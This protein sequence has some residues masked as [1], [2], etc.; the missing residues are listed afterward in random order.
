MA[1]HPK[2][3]VFDQFAI[4]SSSGGGSNVE[5]GPWSQNPPSGGAD[6]P[7]PGGGGGIDG[8]GANIHLVGMQLQL[9]KLEGEVNAY[10][11]LFAAIIAILIGG[12]A[13]LGVQITRVDG[14]V[15]A[16]AAEVQQLPGKINRNLLDLTRTLSDA[17]TAAKQ[18]PPQ[19]ILMPAPTPPNNGQQKP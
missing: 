15:S 2:L 6:A 14:K 13:F 7:A 5:H 19:V 12:F 8:G 3:N 17:I 9:A 10:K 18:Q 1:G 16:T 4:M 11:L